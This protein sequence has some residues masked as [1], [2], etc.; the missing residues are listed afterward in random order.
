MAKVL[1][2]PLVLA[3]RSAAFGLLIALW[4]G[5]SPA[6]AQFVC[7]GSAN[8]GEPQTGDGATAT[9]SFDVACGGAAA[10]ATES[11]AYGTNSI[12]SADNSSAYG[13]LSHAT[14]ISSAAYGDTSHATGDFSSAYGNSSTASADS[15]SAYGVLSRATSRAR[16]MARTAQRAAP[17]PR[18]LA[19]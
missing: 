10:S 16:P 9:G 6:A 17:A 7:G 5:I 13:V 3:C 1:L 8:G 2:N 12:A 11:S 4:F 19:P 18:R 15:S 14:G